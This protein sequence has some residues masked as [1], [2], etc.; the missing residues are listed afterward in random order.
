MVVRVLLASVHQAVGLG[1][2]LAG[3]VAW[4]HEALHVRAY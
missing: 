4:T 2:I 1:L 3:R